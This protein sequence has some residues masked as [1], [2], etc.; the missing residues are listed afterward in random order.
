MRL[1]LIAD[2]KQPG[3]F[4]TA[5]GLATERLSSRYYESDGYWRGPIWAPA[6]LMVVDGLESSGENEFARELKLRFCRMA[7]RS[8]LTENYDAVSGRGLRD[9]AYTW[10][11]SVFLIFAHEL[12]H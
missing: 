4:L 6:T 1:K 11:A 12:P 2:L 5:N 3:Q 9:G 8:G 10:T 7:A